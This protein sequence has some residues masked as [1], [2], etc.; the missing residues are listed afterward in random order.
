MGTFRIDVTPRT[1]HAS[2]SINDLLT[3][4]RALGAAG[5]EGVHV[6]RVYFL[7]GEVSSDEID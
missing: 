3:E 6:S 1:A 5:V 2:E 7:S 4:A